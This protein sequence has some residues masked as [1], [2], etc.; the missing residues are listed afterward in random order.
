MYV[1]FPQGISDCSLSGYAVQGA[2][3][4][5]Y[6]SNFTQKVTEFTVTYGNTTETCY[7][8]YADGSGEEPTTHEQETGEEET[9]VNPWKVVDNSNSKL[10]YNDKTKERIQQIVNVQKPPFADENGIYI[11]V[12]EGITSISVNG[13]MEN[14]AA[15]Q[16]AGAVI[17]LSAL[18]RYHN[19]VT[20]VEGSNLSYIEIRNVDGIL[21]Y[22]VEDYKSGETAS[23][24]E[25]DNEIFAGWFTD[26]TYSTVYDGTSGTAYAKFIDANVLSFKSQWQLPDHNAVRFVSTVDSVNYDKVGFIFTGTYGDKT[27]NK[28]DKEVTKVYKDIKAAGKNV[29]PTVF[30]E[31]STYFFIYTIRNMDGSKA[32]TWSVTPYYVTLDGTKVLGKTG[33]ASWTP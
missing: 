30:S 18:T 33:K 15:I 28:T 20:F 22:D 14:V 17:Y 7:V 6:I 26:D 12:P 19:K 13:K 1:T 23:Y 16:G 24:P 10:Y 4:V 32:S 29:K 21:E 11:T 3:I 27:I 2:G 25:K 5:I 9:T 31:S 8:Y